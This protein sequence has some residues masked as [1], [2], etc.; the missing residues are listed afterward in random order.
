M[1]EKLLNELYGLR[2]KIMLMPNSIKR[3]YLLLDYSH[4]Y[5]YLKSLNINVTDDLLDFDNIDRIN[6]IT[7][8]G[9][10]LQIGEFILNNNF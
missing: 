1:G 5:K 6:K 3:D 9:I 4:L 2:K 8:D 10:Y 7:E